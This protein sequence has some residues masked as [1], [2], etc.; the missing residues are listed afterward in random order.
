[1]A[2]QTTETEATLALIHRFD[3]VGFNTHDVD[4]IMVDATEDTVY[5]CIGPPEYRGRS[6]GP[7]T[8]RAVWEAYFEAIP[9]CHFDTDDIFATGDRCF[10]SWT[11]T[12]TNAD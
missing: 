5:E 10:Y 1:M 6:V 9:D 12:L 3:G 7:A 2:I 8:V 11:M 4:A